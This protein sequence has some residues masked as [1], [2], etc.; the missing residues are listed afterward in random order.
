M[1]EN[2][3]SHQSAHAVSV[4]CF[5]T[6]CQFSDFAEVVNKNQVLVFMT[7]M[8]ETVMTTKMVM[9]RTISMVM[10]SDLA[11]L[12]RNLKASMP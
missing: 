1:D 10:M 6:S 9:I 12:P 11:S 5:F 2:F 3:P 4:K 8:S 7:I